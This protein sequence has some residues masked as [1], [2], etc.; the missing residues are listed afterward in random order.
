MAA[1][2]FVIAMQV[3]FA[4]VLAM[5]H[6]D[7]GAMTEFF[8]NA[9]VIAGTIVSFVAN[10]KVVVTRDAFAEAF[11]LPTERMISFLDITPQTVV[12]MRRKNSGT[13]VPFRSPNKKKEMKMEYRLLH[14]IVARN[15]FT[16]ICGASE[17][18]AEESGEH[19]PWRAREI[20]PTQVLNGKSV[21][22]YMK[23]NLGVGPAGE[24]SKVSGA[25]VSEQ[26]S[27]VDSTQS[28]TK[29]PEK[30]ASEIK[31]PD[32]VAAEKKKIRKKCPS[33]LKN[34]VYT[35][36]GEQSNSPNNET[37]PTQAGPHHIIVPEPQV[38]I[39][40]AKELTS[41]KDIVSSIES[42]VEQIK[43][44]TF[45]AKHTTLQFK[46]QLEIKIDGMETKIDGLE[47]SLVRHFVDSKTEPCG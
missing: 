30:E 17:C 2:F 46:R 19:R 14:D 36:Q 1:S 33:G 31:K 22:T 23:K 25:T 10:R 38:N 37:D 45:I 26:Q 39:S 9:K 15:S 32:K 6:T 40:T 47:T 27:T 7:M 42:K 44:D 24:T 20:T 4:S 13:D 43:D 3:D 28:L 21:E 12:E 35:A 11:G 18:S 41:L 5:E 16:K 29:K 8:P 34:V